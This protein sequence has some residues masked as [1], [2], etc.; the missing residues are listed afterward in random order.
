MAI[1][2]LSEQEKTDWVNLANQCHR[3]HKNDTKEQLL[4]QMEHYQCEIE[5]AELMKMVLDNILRRKFKDTEYHI[6]IPTRK[7]VEA[8]ELAFPKY[9][10]RT[11]SF[12]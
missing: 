6:P 10:P 3:D 4:F 7:A 12:G 5:K 8:M 11:F 9:E 2:K 1:R